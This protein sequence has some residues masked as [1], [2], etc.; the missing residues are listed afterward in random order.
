M[1]SAA[2]TDANFN[3]LLENYTTLA[4]LPKGSPCDWSELFSMTTSVEPGRYHGIREMSLE[5]SGIWWKIKEW[6]EKVWIL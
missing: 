5:K 1:L 6:W 3:H 4:N 2:V